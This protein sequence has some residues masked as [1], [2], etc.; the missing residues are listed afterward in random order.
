MAVLST[1]CVGVLTFGSG[2][3]TYSG[4][5]YFSAWAGFFISY[6]ILG[7]VLKNYFGVG[8][9]GV[10]A[11]P[12]PGG[13]RSITT[14]AAEVPP[15]MTSTEANPTTLPSDIPATDDA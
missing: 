15:N 3:A 9:G 10:A 7:N 12:A 4:N 13:S 6:S 14:T 1:V 2:P 8:N 11:S 5:Q